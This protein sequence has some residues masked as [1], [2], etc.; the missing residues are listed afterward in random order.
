MAAP[1]PGFLFYFNSITSQNRPVREIL[2]GCPLVLHFIDT[3]CEVNRLENLPR[4][5]RVIDVHLATGL[6]L[7]SVG[8]VI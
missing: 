8:F 2:L 4:S 1:T 5:A 6:Y 3:E 7:D